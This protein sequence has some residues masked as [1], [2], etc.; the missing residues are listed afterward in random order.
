MPLADHRRRRRRRLWGSGEDARLG[1]PASS[2]S[3]VSRFAARVPVARAHP[4]GP[5]P[6]HGRAASTAYRK[7][8]TAPDGT[9]RVSFPDGPNTSHRYHQSRSSGPPRTS[10]EP[11]GASRIPPSRTSIACTLSPRLIRSRA[12]SARQAGVSPAVA[13]FAG[14]TRAPANA[15]AYNPAAASSAAIAEGSPAAVPAACAVSAATTASVKG[16]AARFSGSRLD[17]GNRITFL[18]TT[19]RA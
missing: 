4:S 1:R 18:S 7:C 6:C 13:A 2:P 11:T 8:K 16:T 12:M 9:N 5:T 15:C 17:Q 14:V 10:H 19:L 3:R